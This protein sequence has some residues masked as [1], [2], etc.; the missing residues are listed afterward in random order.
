MSTKRIFFALWPDDRQRTL[1]PHRHCNISKHRQREP[2]LDKNFIVNLV[3][4]ADCRDSI[5]K[6]GKGKR[7]GNGK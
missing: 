2:E 6:L 5:A 7:H 1:R 3:F 4:V